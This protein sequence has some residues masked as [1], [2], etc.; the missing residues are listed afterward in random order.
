MTTHACPFPIA[1]V[2]SLGQGDGVFK[3]DSVIPLSWN[4]IW[5][6]RRTN[7]LNNSLNRLPHVQ[8][9]GDGFD[10]KPI[11]LLNTCNP[12]HSKSFSAL[13]QEGKLLKSRWLIANAHCLS[14]LRR[15]V[16][17][18][19]RFWRSSQ[20]LTKQMAYKTVKLFVLYHSKVGLSGYHKMVSISDMLNLNSSGV[21]IVFNQ[22]SK[23]QFRT[24]HR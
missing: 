1:L 16:Q 5:L 21:Y 10:P 19:P 24:T 22:Q 7:R 14:N 18:W 15:S 17:Y 12:S 11:Y 8:A 20:V 13:K 3:V 9:E 4:C 2:K 6:V 23:F